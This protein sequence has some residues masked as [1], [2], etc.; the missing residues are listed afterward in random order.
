MFLYNPFKPE[1]NFK[2]LLHAPSPP[3]KD[4]KGVETHK[5]NNFILKTWELQDHLVYLI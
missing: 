3:K 2:D 5:N 1:M 4:R